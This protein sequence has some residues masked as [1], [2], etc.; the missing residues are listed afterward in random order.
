VFKFD[1]YEREFRA[2]GDDA[3]FLCQLSSRISTEATEALKEGLLAS[4]RVV[5]AERVAIN[6]ALGRV[7]VQADDVHGVVRSIE[8]LRSQLSIESHRRRRSEDRAEVYREML[9]SNGID[10]DGTKRR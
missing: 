1:Y 9:V 5:Y 3:E 4:E 2:F 6:R 10:P 7:V 8:L